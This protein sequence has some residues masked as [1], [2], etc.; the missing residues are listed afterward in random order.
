MCSYAKIVRAI[1]ITTLIFNFSE[2]FA[3][4]S[5]LLSD[6]TFQLNC[7]TEQLDNFSPRAEKFLRHSGFKA[8]DLS[9]LQMRYGKA[10]IPMRIIGID[11][12]GRIVDFMAFEYSK[13]KIFITLLSRPPTQHD[14]E[15]EN[16]IISFSS[17]FQECKLSDISRSDNGSEAI[18][19]YNSQ[20]N[21][22]NNLFR[23]I[24]DHAQ[25]RR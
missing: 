23:E 12:A 3:D 9:K 6:M 1:L 25:E 2:V 15:L 18:K 22:T 19:F 7:D 14:H 5:V 11:N 24:G 10:I 13:K 20:V 4:D 16:S 8:I 21:R 17:A